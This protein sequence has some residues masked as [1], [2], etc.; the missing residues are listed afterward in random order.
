SRDPSPTLT[1]HWR[2]EHR[3]SGLN[4]ITDPFLAATPPDTVRVRAGHRVRVARI[5][6]NGAV[7]FAPLKTDH[8]SLTLTSSTGLRLNY[9]P[10][11]H[12]QTRLGIGVSEVVVPGVAP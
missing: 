4:I 12:A 10:F 11:R 2:G 8:M 7:A 5:G 6:S 1:L 3:I 9:D